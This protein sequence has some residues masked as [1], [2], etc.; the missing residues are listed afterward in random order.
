M[1]Y[2]G[3]CVFKVLK[4]IKFNIE[5]LFI[6]IIDVILGTILFTFDLAP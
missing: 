4:Y 5:C 3:L 2:S 1:I 6:K